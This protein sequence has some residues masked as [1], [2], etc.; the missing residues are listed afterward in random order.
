MRSLNPAFKF[1][2]LL[3]PTFFLAARPNPV[4]NFVVL[5]L[6]LILLLLSKVS[7]KT[8]ALL[9]APVILVAICA[10]STGYHFSADAGLPV[11]ATILHFNSSEL[12]NGLLFA[13]R[14]LAYAG[15]GLLFSLTTDRVLLIHSFRRQFRLPTV[16]AYGMLAAWGIFPHMAQE[17]KKTFAA[18]RARGLRVLPFSP[19]VLGPLL[20]KSIRWSEELSIAMESKGF[21][22]NAP[23]SEFDPPK[24]RLCDYLFCMATCVVFPIFI[25]LL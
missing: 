1:I 16:F 2:G 7:I 21:S 17:Y 10:F 11:R 4:V 25:I 23:R 24:V 12:Y 20:V 5:F 8:L 6:C 19:S 18:F 13:S 14:V 15:L 3:F 9:F 22:G